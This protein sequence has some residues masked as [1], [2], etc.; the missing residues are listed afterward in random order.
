M[1]KFLKTCKSLFGL[2]DGTLFSIA[3]FDESANRF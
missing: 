1:K 2:D 3:L